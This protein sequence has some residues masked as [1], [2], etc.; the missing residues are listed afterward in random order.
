MDNPP[1]VVRRERLDKLVKIMRGAP[2]SRVKL[3]IRRQGV[4][5]PLSFDLTR[6]LFEGSGGALPSKVVVRC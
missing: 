6:E 2:G 5:E 3:T 4:P 1:I